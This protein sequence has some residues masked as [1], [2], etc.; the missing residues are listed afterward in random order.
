MR[1]LL[2]TLSLIFV[3]ACAT[4]NGKMANT[5]PHGKRDVASTAAKAC[6]I[7]PGM[8]DW[9]FDLIPTEFM[10]IANL[11]SKPDSHNMGAYL[12]INTGGANSC[13]ATAEFAKK[14][15]VTLVE[16]R[17]LFAEPNSRITCRP[18]NSKEKV[19]QMEV[20]HFSSSLQ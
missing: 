16:L 13:N 1:L 12:R 20:T 9:C 3:T 17:T 18:N 4:S 7:R 6:Y 14:A 15:G 2:F 10:I 8:S 19:G 5:Q 11:E